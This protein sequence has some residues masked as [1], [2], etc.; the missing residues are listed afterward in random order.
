MLKIETEEFVLDFS[1]IVHENNTYD[2]AKLINY[3]KVKS[4]LEKIHPKAKI[5]SIADARTH[6]I[7]DQ[8]QEF[9]SLILKDNII[10]APA[11]E[12]ADYYIY[13]YAIRHPT[14][15]IISNDQFKQYQN[16]INFKKRVI[17]YKIINNDIIFSAKLKK[18]VSTMNLIHTT[19]NAKFALKNYNTAKF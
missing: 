15:V 13:E 8:K 3:R 4:E 10:Q 17:P 14:A 9:K 19:I 18:Y 1:N 11:G 7:I 5:S 2:H 16:N 6:H 12:K